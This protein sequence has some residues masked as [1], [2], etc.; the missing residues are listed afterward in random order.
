MENRFHSPSRQSECP[1]CGARR[2]LRHYLNGHKHCFACGNHTFPDGKKETMNEGTFTP[3]LPEVGE[4]VYQ[5]IPSRNISLDTAKKYGYLTELDDK[6][7]PYAWHSTIMT[8]DEETLGTIIRFMPNS[9]QKFASYLNG[10]MSKA[11]LWGSQLF[12]AGSAKAITVTEG[13]EDAMAAYEMMGSRWPTVSINAGCNNAA[14]E[15]KANYEYLNSFEKVYICFDGDDPGKKAALECANIL[16]PGKVRI[17]KLDPGLKDAC[18]YKIANRATDFTK[19]WWGAATYT[20]AGILTGKQ[21]LERL[22]NK[23]AVPAL[24]FPFDGLN[25]LTYGIRCGEAIVVT[26]P[27][28]VGKSSL[29]RETMYGILKQDPEAKIGSMFLEEKPEDTALGLMSIEANKPL[30][31]PDTEYTDEEYEL[32][33]RIIEDDRVFYYDSFGSNKIDEIISR[34]RYYAQGLGCKYIFL[35]HLSIIVSDQSQGDERKALDSIM[36]QLKT[37]TIELNIALI[38]VVHTNRQGQIRGTAGIEQLANIVITLDRDTMNPDPGIRSTLKVFVAKNRFSGKTGPACECRYDA[39]TGRTNEIAGYMPTQ[40]DVD[41]VFNTIE[42][43]DNEGGELGSYPGADG[44]GTDQGTDDEEVT[45]GADK[46]TSD[47]TGL[48]VG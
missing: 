18:G 1:E 38:C 8:R 30:H 42:S 4:L 20:P 23:V 7:Q 21:V 35:D 24:M 40:E 16:P 2:G 37:L 22:K 14:K 11:Q 26:A 13:R 41:R 17:V 9:R 10:S 39:A 25:S 15:F 5:S 29:L 27:T 31:L 46:G 44:F 6:G 34:V 28:G 36:T 33:K 48:V 45:L 47:D 32:S 43:Q 12:P 3:T 19:D